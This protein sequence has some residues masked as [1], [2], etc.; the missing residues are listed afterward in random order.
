MI[1]ELKTIMEV[2]FMVAKGT[3]KDVDLKMSDQRQEDQ[4]VET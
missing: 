4:N 1:K 2:D 3:S